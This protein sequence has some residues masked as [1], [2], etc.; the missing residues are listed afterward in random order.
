MYLVRWQRQLV[1]EECSGVVCRYGETVPSIS[2]TL[3]CRTVVPSRA[4]CCLSTILPIDEE[5]CSE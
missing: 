2:Q 1:R 5:S 4:V 3:M